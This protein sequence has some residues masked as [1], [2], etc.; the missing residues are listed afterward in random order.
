[1]P[2]ILNRVVQSTLVVSWFPNCATGWP[3]SKLPFSKGYYSETK[4]FW[5]HVGK[6]K[7]RLRGGSFFLENCKQTAEKSN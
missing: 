7:M 6:A 2:L 3:K 1:M 4:H 5:P